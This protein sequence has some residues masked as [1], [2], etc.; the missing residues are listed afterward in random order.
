MGER[1]VE[2]ASGR[3]ERLCGRGR[4]KNSR[5]ATPGKRFV[6]D[7]DLAALLSQAAMLST[8]ALHFEQMLSFS[9]F[10][11]LVRHV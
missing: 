3:P 11:V 7:E 8:R 10:Q 2:G 9:K 5:A 1:C 4:I 6:V